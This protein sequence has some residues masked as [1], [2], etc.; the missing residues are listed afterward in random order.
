MTLRCPVCDEKRQDADAIRIHNIR[1][2]QTGERA[3]P[4]PIYVPR[5]PRR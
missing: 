2:A 5:P 1:C 4:K 3:Y